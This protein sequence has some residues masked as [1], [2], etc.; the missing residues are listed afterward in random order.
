MGEAVGS[1]LASAVGIAFGPV[2]LIA[3]VL[4][5]ATPRGRSNGV[6]F[7]AG[8]TLTLAALAAA[9][10][11]AASALGL[12]GDRGG[13][14]QLAAGL[15][16]LGMG[17][18]RWRNRPRQ[19]HVTRPPRWLREVDLLT[20][21]RAAALAAAQVVADPKNP[22]L[23]A[24]AAVAV[25]TT[26]VGPGARAVAVAVL[27]LTGS[28]CTLLP[29][30]VRLSG[31]AART[32]TTLGEWKAWTSAHRAAITTVVPLVLGAAYAGDALSVL[33]A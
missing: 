26:G 31:G 20:P 4:V 3:V 29:L 15:A 19:G 24:G 13:W 18:G 21:G 27:A 23:L 14:V 16:L 32:A 33:T 8:W 9:A 5:L 12:R 30:A 7:A 17:L 11:T 1:V 28:L 2:P 22:V 10:V 6:A 25:T